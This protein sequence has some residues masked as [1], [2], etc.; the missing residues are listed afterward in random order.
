MIISWKNKNNNNNKKPI[1]PLNF[2]L[3]ISC[4]ALLS[5][6]CHQILLVDEG[7]FFTNDFQLMSEKKM[8]ELENYH[9]ATTNKFEAGND[10]Q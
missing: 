4:S 8:I 9:F 1:R 7:K 10:H 2:L 6:P 5:F 3:I